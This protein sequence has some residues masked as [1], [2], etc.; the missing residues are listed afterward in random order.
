MTSLTDIV[1]GALDLV[2]APRCLACGEPISTRASERAV[3]SGCWTRARGLPLPRCER[4]WT[5]LRLTIGD[6]AAECA[7]CPEIRPAVRAIRSTFLLEGPIRSVVHALKY[8]GWYS[9]AA[10]MARRMSTVDWPREVSSEVSRVVPVPISSVKRRQ[11]GFNQAAVLAVELARI[12]GWEAAEEVLERCR[13]AASQTALH[14]G[15]RRANV[16]GAFRVPGS[17]RS[18]I[19]AEHLLLLDDVWTTGATAL[20]C[21]DALLAGGARAVSVLTFARALPELERH[22]RRLEAAAIS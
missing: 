10:P 4:C 14:P 3:C 20:S 6:A 7:A 12:N 16:A 17:Q 15:E 21:A 9:L 19:A 8:R 18:R 13:S 2:F 1:E 22:E 5:P 11:R